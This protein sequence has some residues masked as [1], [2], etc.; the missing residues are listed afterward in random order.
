[1]IRRPAIFSNNVKSQDTLDSKSWN[2]HNE[3]TQY[4]LHSLHP[5]PARFI[6]QIPNK[7][8]SIWSKKGETVLDPFCGCGTTLLEGILLQRKMIGIDNNS[9]ACLVSRA[10]IEKYTNSDLVE[11]KNFCVNF[12]NILNSIRPSKVWIPEYPQLKFWFDENAIHDLSRINTSLEL[13]SEKPK[14]FSLAVFSSIIVRASFQ[15]SDTRYCKV[16]REYIP[17]SALKWF[18]SRLIDSIKRL[19]LIIDLPRGTGQVFLAD[20]K[21]MD[22]IRD[23]SVNL[24]VTSPPYLNA[25]DYHKYHRQRIH[26]VKGDVNLARNSEIGKHDTFTRPRATPDRYFKEMKMCFTEWYRVLL[27]NGR[28]FVVIGDAI[29]GGQPVA[30]ADRFVEI[31]E[32][33]GFFYENHWIRELEKSKKS[34]N[35][36][37]RINEE[38]VILI[39]K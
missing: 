17:G 32:E 35:Q 28:A 15:D 29:V 5:Y 16:E 19:E 23:E 3:D 31:F 39:K 8:I 22:S 7:A 12:D 10:K 11:M 4:H 6:P 30:V 27:N 37:A 13:L 36:A 2:F 24:I 38:H 1:M 25:Y 14:L 18:K 26:W 34:F 33:L 9:I 20:S 21:K